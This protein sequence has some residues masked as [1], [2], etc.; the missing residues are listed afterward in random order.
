MKC[1]LCNQRKGKRSCPAKNTSICAQ[2]CGEQRVTTIAC[3]ADCVYLHSGQAYQAIKKY[4]TQL[5]NEEDPVKRR[6][7]YETSQAFGPVFGQI[8]QSIINYAASLQTLTDTHVLEAVTLLRETYRTEQ[9]GV[10]FE[11]SSGHPLVQALVRDLKAALEALRA[12][13]GD[14]LPKVSTTDLLDCLSV[15]E[16][17]IS[18]HLDS[19]KD[20]ES[21]LNFI[22]RNH[23]ELSSKASSR[24]TLIQP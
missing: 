15:V 8:E 2:C 20:R 9:K 12:D 23:P 5:K 10:I 4:S 13:Q 22:R 3:P 24:G 7:L 18:Y 1:I 19:S 6:K 14:H 16:T 11:H 17:D 21:Y